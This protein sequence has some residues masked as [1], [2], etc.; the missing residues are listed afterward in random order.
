MLRQARRRGDAWSAPATVA[1]GTDWFINW[2]DFPSVVPVTSTLWVA[3][4]LQQRPGNVYSYDVRMRTSADG[5]ATWSES[6]S[7]HDDGTPTEHG[8]VSIVNAGG[9]PYVVWLDGRKTAGEG[10]SHDEDHAGATG[11]MTLRGAQVNGASARLRTT[12]KSTPVSATAA[13]RMPW[14]SATLS[15]VV[16]RDRSADETRDIRLARLEAGHRSAPV[17][18]HDDGWRI[19][20]CPVNGPAIDA[21]G[22]VV[23]VAWFTAPDQPRVRLAFS[24]DAGKSF[25]EPFEV[26]AGRVLGRVD[27]VVLPDGRAITSW[28]E[29]GSDGALIRAQPFTVRGAAGPAQTIARSAIARSSGF[30][31]MRLDGGNLVFAWTETGEPAGIR[32][33]VAALH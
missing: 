1:E 33:A 32:T 21:S 19:D 27:L 13:R 29:Q 10:H 23:A 4:W 15:L 25:A 5:G 7:P 18:V 31:Q 20:A 12:P 30:P 17:V 16:Y 14:A 11:A 6:F 28:L 8:F 22:N 24:T 9:Q 26:A 3:H 2:A